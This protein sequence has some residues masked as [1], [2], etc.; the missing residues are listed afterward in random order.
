MLRIKDVGIALIRIETS[1]YVTRWIV[2][3]N[4]LTIPRIKYVT[5]LI[6]YK[7]KKHFFGKW[8]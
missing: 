7:S 6:K 5:N 4:K 1:N 3:N 2:E 8:L